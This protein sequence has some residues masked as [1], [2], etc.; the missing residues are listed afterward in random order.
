VEGAD[1]GLVEGTVPAFAWKDSIPAG[2]RTGTKSEAL[3]L[4]LA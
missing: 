4:E 1:L 2:I 3:P